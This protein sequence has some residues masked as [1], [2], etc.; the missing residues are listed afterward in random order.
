MNKLIYILFL[1]VLVACKKEEIPVEK[2]EPGEAVVNAFDMGSDYRTQAFF[3]L[4]T[5]SFVSQN[6]KTSW[7]LGFENGVNG[8]HIILNSANAMAIARVSNIGFNSIT[9]TVGLKWRWD[10]SSGNLDS[11]AIGDWEVEDFVYVV[12]RGNDYLGN[13]RGFCKLVFNNVTATDYSFR[14]ANLDGSLDEQKTILKDNS[15]S[16]TA[17]SLTNRAVE[18]VE[19]PKTDWD[20][21]FTQYVHYFLV[22]D[23]A[24]LVTGILT[25]RHEVQVAEVFNKDYASITGEDVSSVSFNSN[26]DVIGYDWKEFN[27]SAGAYIIYP[28]QNYIIRSTEGIY[29]KLH[30]IDF[31]NAQGDKGTPVFELQEL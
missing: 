5:N 23:E 16:F 3:D 9:D 18:V 6:L 24:Y 17:F 27:F 10:A 11:T 1:L 30:F 14:V 12:N 25:N 4:K 22:E 7:D 13:H 31:Y 15:L 29:F 19:P 2:H 21:I 26:I 28:E 8:N 20:L